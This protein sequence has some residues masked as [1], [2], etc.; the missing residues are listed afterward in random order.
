MCF[1]FQAEDG[2]RDLVRSRGLGD[3]YKRQDYELLFTVGGRNESTLERQACAKRFLVT[4]IGTIR[5]PRSGLHA[6]T[7]DGKRTPLPI[8]SYRHFA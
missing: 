6:L 2:I 5:P 8:T 7:S 1:F 3:V 4:K